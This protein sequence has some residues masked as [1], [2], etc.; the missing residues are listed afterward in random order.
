MIFVI[1]KSCAILELGSPAMTVSRLL[2][3]ILTRFWSTTVGLGSVLVL[4]RS[5]VQS[6]FSGGE[7]VRVLCRMLK[8]FLSNLHTP[9]RHRGSARFV[10]RRTETLECINTVTWERFE[11][12][13]HVGVLVLI[14]LNKSDVG[15]F[16]GER[17]NTFYSYFTSFLKII[18][19]RYELRLVPLNCLLKKRKRYLNVLKYEGSSERRTE[20]GSSWLVLLALLGLLRLSAAASLFLTSLE[21]TAL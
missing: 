9:R 16:L 7:E 8:T 3:R 4:W 5:G 2:G 18:Y 10:F 17:G 14:R 21:F 12:E 15:T 19:Q 1:P 6:V 11:D 20:G 13:P